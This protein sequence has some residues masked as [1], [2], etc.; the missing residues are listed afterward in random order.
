MKG[1]ENNTGKLSEV[2]MLT[3]SKVYPV[4]ECPIGKSMIFMGPF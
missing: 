3:V 1:D 2:P 4:A